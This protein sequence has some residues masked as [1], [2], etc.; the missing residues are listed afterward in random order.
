MKLLIGVE[1]LSQGVPFIHSGMEICSTKKGISN[2]YKSGDEVNGFRWDRIQEYKDVLDYTKKM[3]AFRS[4]RD[5]LWEY[6]DVYFDIYDNNL[7]QYD[8]Y[9]LRILINPHKEDIFFNFHEDF[10]LVFDHDGN[11]GGTLSKG[12]IQGLSV[13][14]F[15]RKN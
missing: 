8:I 5:Y 13:Y 3:I 15:E 4:K 10:E 14:V 6:N 9:D 1:L 12:N 7:V 11:N 2:S